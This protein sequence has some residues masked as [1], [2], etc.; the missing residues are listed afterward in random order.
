MTELLPTFKYQITTRSL[1]ET[2]KLGKIIGT[3]VTAGTVLALTGNLG[4]GKTSFVQG[5]ARGLEVPDDYYITS[6]SYTLINEYPG[7][8]PL[9]HVDLYRISDPM[10]M[11]DIGLYEILHNSGIA[12]IE[13]ADRIEQKLLPDSINIHFEL[14]GDKT[15]KICI[16]AYDL[17][18][19]DL[20]K[21]ILCNF[22]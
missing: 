13:W 7:R 1:D 15:R 8:Y 4:S 21:N 6:P 20:L 5:L 3:A 14:T 10:D 12:A 22:P 11:E 18:N 2:K 16:T 19:A 17:K 9:F